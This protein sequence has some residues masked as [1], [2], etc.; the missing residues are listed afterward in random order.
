MVITRDDVGIGNGNWFRVMQVIPFT[1]VCG[2]CGDKVSSKEGYYA[3]P[4]SDGSGS[5]I[6]FIRICPSCKG[7]TFFSPFG[8]QFPESPPGNPVAHVPEQLY[9]LYNEARYSIAAGAYTGAVL[10]CRKMLM[11]IAVNEGAEE[12]KSFTFYVEY[13]ANKG[14]VPPNGKAWVDYIRKRGNDANHEI[15]LMTKEDAVSLI[16]FLEMLLR[17]IYEFP[18]SIPPEAQYVIRMQSN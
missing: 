1:Y 4:H 11:N 9:K 7:P 16:T 3:G 8:K 12:G 15:E 5:P 10:I 18:K 14:Y 17:F 6:A 2:F 13:L